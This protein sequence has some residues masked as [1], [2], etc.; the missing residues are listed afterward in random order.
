MRTVHLRVTVRMVDT[1]GHAVDV[2]TCVPCLH[3][4]PIACRCHLDRVLAHV[5]VEFR[6]FPGGKITVR[7]AET[8]LFALVNEP[9]VAIE[10][11]ARL[12]R[13]VVSLGASE[14]QTVHCT[15]G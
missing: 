3:L 2:D 6:L 13:G 10:A 4:R 1:I 5:L 14:A 12:C 15:D 8:G 7:A 11:G 9:R